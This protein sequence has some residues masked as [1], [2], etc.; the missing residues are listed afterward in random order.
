M[1]ILCFV[2]YLIRRN[3]EKEC[4][5]EGMDEARGDEE[6]ECEV[7]TSESY[8]LLEEGLSSKKKHRSCCRKE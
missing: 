3:E 1:I 4:L 6:R 8:C 5:Q 7:G 2:G